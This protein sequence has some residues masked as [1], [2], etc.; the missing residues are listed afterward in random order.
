M[1]GN[2]HPTGVFFAKSDG[3]FRKC[4]HTNV[5]RFTQTPAHY[6]G[7]GGC[8]KNK[9]EARPPGRCVSG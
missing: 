4:T 8:R 3:A 6:L 9:V 7:G 2:A 1:G 5:S